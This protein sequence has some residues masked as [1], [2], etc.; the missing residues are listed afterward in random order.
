MSTNAAT[1]F[2]IH[3]GLN[4]SRT[5]WAPLE[6]FRSTATLCRGH[7]TPSIS[8]VSEVQPAALA[9]LHDTDSIRQVLLTGTHM[10]VW[11]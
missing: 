4:T 1:G 9:M 5:T 2:C 11:D 7:K 8:T 10:H 6:C 3:S